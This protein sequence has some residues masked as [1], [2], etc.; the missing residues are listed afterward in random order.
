MET[1]VQQFNCEPGEAAGNYV[2][3]LMS[4]LNPTEMNYK[5]VQRSLE[6]S[7]HV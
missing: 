3:R 1:H 6:D 7:F 2:S 5:Y 4:A